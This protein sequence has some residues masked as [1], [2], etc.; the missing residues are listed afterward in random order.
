MDLVKLGKKGQLSIPQHVLRRVGLA[1]EAPLSVET[2][3]DGAIVL[4]PVGVYP[5]ELYDDARVAALLDE[6]RMPPEL[7]R[8]VAAAT[9]ATR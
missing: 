9:R 8:R 2:T 4:R 6:D 7:G 1:G 3:A 5:I